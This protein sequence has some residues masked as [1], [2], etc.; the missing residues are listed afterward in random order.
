MRKLLVAGAVLLSLGLSGC[1]RVIM[2]SYV[3]KPVMEIVLDYGPP[4]NAIDLEPG[5]RAFQWVRSYSG[6]TPMVATTSYSG[7]G[8]PWVTSNTVITGGNPAVRD[9]L[10]TF[11]ATWDAKGS[12]WM[13]DDYR[14]PEF[15]CR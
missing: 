11:T 3:G 6:S 5:R 2:G 15:M 4:V 8:S 13:V 10:Y 1:A 14:L 9:C 12:R 7:V